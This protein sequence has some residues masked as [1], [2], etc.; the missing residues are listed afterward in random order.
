VNLFDH[1]TFIDL[2]YYYMRVTDLIVPKRVAEE[3][4]VGMNAGSSLHRGLEIAVTQWIFGNRNSASNKT[5]SLLG[6]LNYATNRFNFQNFTADNLDFSGKKLPGMP[7][8]NL[9]GSLDLKTPFGFYTR[10][11]LNTSG[12]IPLNDLNSQFSK[13]WVIINITGGYIFNLFKRMNID[14]TVRIKN[15]TNEKYASMI[16][17][18]APGSATAAPRYFY[19]GLPQWIT[20]SLIISLRDFK[21]AN[22]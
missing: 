10:M 17:V 12:R 3:I 20:C 19:P 2:A 5:Y 22:I 1:A 4:Y 14:A 16:V 7:D 15:L 11:E 18:N 21:R 13:G 6:N 8:Q 9:S